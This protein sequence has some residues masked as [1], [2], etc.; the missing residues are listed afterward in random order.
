MSGCHPTEICKKHNVPF[1]SYM[2]FMKCPECNYQQMIAS[3]MSGCHPSQC[4]CKCH[5]SQNECC[6]NCTSTSMCTIEE[7]LNKLEQNDRLLRSETN[8]TW[9]SFENTLNKFQEQHIRQID[10]NRKISRRV[11]E[12]EKRINVLN[13]ENHNLKILLRGLSEQ[14]E[15]KQPY[16]CP[17]CDGSSFS[18]E[19]MCC[20]PCDGTGILWG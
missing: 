12:S 16:K 10:E 3:D 19:G 1:I 17:L 2:G 18:K 14:V 20:V 4:T 15:N 9:N 5:V 7:R 11:D 8:K 13:L 6:I